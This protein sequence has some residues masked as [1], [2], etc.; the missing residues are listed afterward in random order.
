M[1][2]AFYDMKTP[3]LLVDQPS[4]GITQC[5]LPPGVVTF[6][7]KLLL[8]LAT[9]EGCKAELVCV[10][11]ISQDSLPAKDRL[12]ILEITRQCHDQELKLQVPM[13]KEL[14]HPP[15]QL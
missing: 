1:A 12:P 6:P 13:S 11:V 15:S 7:P 10:V 2:K 5:Y 4:Y 14:D 3:S 8:D 9:P